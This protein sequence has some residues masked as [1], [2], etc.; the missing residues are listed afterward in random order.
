[1]N[2]IEL[3]T[4]TICL[5]ALIMFT[6]LIVIIIKKTSVENTLE[7]AG[8]DFRSLHQLSKELSDKAKTE[9]LEHLSSMYAAQ[10]LIIHEL[11][12]KSLN[13]HVYSKPKK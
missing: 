4:I 9:K 5:I 6:G 3:M 7:R 1:M 13:I 10:S 2:D 11:K 8:L 12:T